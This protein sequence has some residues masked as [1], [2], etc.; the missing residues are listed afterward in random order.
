MAELILEF[1]DTA[2]LQTLQEYTQMWG[3][4]SMTERK[5]QE[6]HGYFGKVADNQSSGIK[7][8]CQ[9]PTLVYNVL[10]VLDVSILHLTWL[11][12]LHHLLCMPSSVIEACLSYFH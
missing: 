1:L 10:H 12:W 5:S 3:R 9:N 7:I 4:E 2:Q 11:K 6:A 8:G